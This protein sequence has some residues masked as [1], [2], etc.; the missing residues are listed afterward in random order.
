MKKNLLLVGC[1]FILHSAAKG[2]FAYI[3]DSSFRNFL[4]AHG[5][6]ACMSGDSLDTTC[7]L[8]TSATTMNCAM[9]GIV[10]LTGLEYFTNLRTL[11]CSNNALTFLPALPDSMSYLDCDANALTSLPAL[12]A[13]MM[14][15]DCS[16]NQITSLPA[17]PVGLYSLTCGSNLLATLPSLPY[18]LTELECGNPG[19]LVLPP[20]PAGMTDLTCVI[21]DITSF[22]PLPDSLVNFF[23]YD[24]S[25]TSLPLLPSR[26]EY[27]QC[28]MNQLTSLP[29]LPSSLKYLDCYENQ[30]AA[31]PVLPNSILSIR[32]SMNQLSSLPA[33]P[34]ALTTLECYNNALVSLPTLPSTLQY[35]RCQNNQLASLP[36][37]SPVLK[38]LICN[39]NFIPSISSFPPTLYWLECD[40]NQ[41]SSLPPFQSMT[42]I[43]QHF[44]CMTNNI[45]ALPEL[46]DSI[47]YIRIN[48]NAITCLPELKKI[49]Q[50][51]W[52]G[53]AISCLPNVGTV[54]NSTPLIDTVPLC[55]PFSFCP[56]FWNIS[57][58]VFL[59]ADSDCTLSATEQ[60]LRDVPVHLDSGSA[61][62]QQMLTDDYGRFSFE[63]GYGNY[64]ISIDTTNASYRVVCPVTFSGSSVLTVV[65]SMDTDI[66][67][68][69]ICKPGID[70][71]SRSIVPGRFFRPGFQTLVYLNAGDAMAFSSVTCAQGVSGT[72]QAVISSLASYVAPANGALTPSSVNGDTVTWNISDF[73]SVDPVHDFNIITDVSTSA[74]I[75]DS[76][77]IQLSISPSVDNIPSNNYLSACYPV[78][79]SYDPNEKY[80]SPSGL[81]DTSQQW[82]TFI[83][84]FQNTGTA[85][86]E[87]I[88]ILDTLDDGL[89]A[90]TFT[91]LSSSHDAVTQLLPENIL[92][93]NFPN[94]NLP[95]SNANEPLSHG[96]VQ[97]KV[98]RKDNLP[99]NT[100]ISNTAYIFFD[101][102]PTVATNTVEAILVSEV[103][104]AD[105]VKDDIFIYPNPA[106]D[107]FAVGSHQSAIGSI[108]MMN[109]FGQEITIRYAN[110]KSGEALA[111]LSGLK[112]GI[113]FLKISTNH[114]PVVKRLIKQ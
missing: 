82:F 95:D 40:Y 53:N 6:T 106:T 85:P 94:I 98:K 3:P 97:Y 57:G 105:V 7:A 54:W 35:L 114:G 80:M 107:Q 100:T 24:N 99:F 108:E 66:N 9:K 14:H 4:N 58:Q 5:Y 96:Y 37:L 39:Y 61:H 18:T 65:D 90:T 56:L 17:L 11:V 12:P 59:D 60:I 83:V 101:F 110:R 91:Y 33:L 92:R 71:T 88:Y 48:N 31:L 28:S 29:A 63:A 16:M 26:L 30:L 1:L 62:L 27:L 69:L 93:F 87:N 81:V 15:L 76:I 46:P 102:N 10:D 41:L 25:L 78:R 43:L 21:S 34:T 38:L 112:P 36:A 51:S 64:S 47:T 70:L 86:A 20:L 45:T 42:T 74:T 77:C 23:C 72:V 111:D 67:F 22:P 52:G 55:D 89:D 13:T 32:C 113:Y 109:V 49:G 44:S 73:S 2:Q 19:F 104:V 68:G 8:V 50:L 103:G 79:G 84:Y 75:N